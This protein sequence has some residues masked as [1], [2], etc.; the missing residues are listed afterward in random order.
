MA[1]VEVKV[2]EEEEAKIE[3]DLS[4]VISQINTDKESH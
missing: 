1:E 3:E 4:Q 2:E